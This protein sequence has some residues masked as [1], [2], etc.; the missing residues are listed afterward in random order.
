MIRLRKT[1]STLFFISTCSVLSFESLSNPAAPES[2][3]ANGVDR[4]GTK[5]A[6]P[7]AAALAHEVHQ[8]YFSRFHFTAGWFTNHANYGEFEIDSDYSSTVN[9]VV[10]GEAKVVS[11]R[12]GFRIDGYGML[13]E[14][15][16]FLG[17]YFDMLF[18]GED[19]DYERLESTGSLEG[20]GKLTEMGFG[21]ASKL[22]NKAGKRSWLGAALDL[23]AIRWDWQFTENLT[24]FRAHLAF[25]ADAVLI[26]MPKLDLG[27]HFSCGV[28]LIPF[29][30]GDLDIEGKATINLWNYGP[31][32]NLGVVMGR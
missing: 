11:I 20:H 5:R 28:Y 32:V 29:M 17:A 10:A 21:L 4:H 8:G 14:D 1:M 26:R 6:S 24:G 15:I 19:I 27:M 3:P 12:S 13:A 16:F 23:G 18:G 2:R 22:G 25:I 30:K 7:A 9:Q 31:T